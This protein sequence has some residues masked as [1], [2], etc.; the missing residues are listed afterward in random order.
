MEFILYD[1]IQKVFSTFL[2]EFH[3]IFRFDNSFMNYPTLSY[4]EK[5]ITKHSNEKKSKIP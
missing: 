4:K 2:L 1:L 5:M 3:K